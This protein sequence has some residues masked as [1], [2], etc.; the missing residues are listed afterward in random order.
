MPSWGNEENQQHDRDV[1]DGG[2]HQLT[3]GGQTTLN[4]G[5]NV[6]GVENQSELL[7]ANM[8]L[9][10]R[11]IGGLAIDDPGAAQIWIASNE[12]AGNLHLGKPDGAGGPN[13]DVIVESP[14]LRVGPGD[15][16]GLID[17][18]GGD[19][20]VS[21]ALC[22]GT[23]SQQTSIVKIGNNVAGQPQHTIQVETQM[24]LTGN[25]IILNGA[26]SIT[27][28]GAEG[29]ISDVPGRIDFVCNGQR[30]GWHDW[31]GFHNPPPPAP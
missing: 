17:A 11:N 12:E 5:L 6:P 23:N 27:D 8:R 16:S 28:A 4:G 31:D 18:N 1:I 2:Q 14:R 7:V 25:A 24:V 30:R 21:R 29:L 20:A 3:V 9:Y 10:Q 15:D 13:A 26:Q 19:P 22:I